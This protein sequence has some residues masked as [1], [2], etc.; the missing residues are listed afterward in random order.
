MAQA[1]EAK[2]AN[3]LAKQTRLEAEDGR[4]RMVRYSR[5][6]TTENRHWSLSWYFR[7]RGWG[8]I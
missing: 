8:L 2:V 7:M 3:Y 6:A 4:Q 5:P 1:A